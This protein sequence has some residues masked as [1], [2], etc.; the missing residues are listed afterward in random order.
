MKRKAMINNIKVEIQFYTGYQEGV[1]M[2]PIA[3][4]CCGL[5]TDVGSSPG[6]GWGQDTDPGG[7]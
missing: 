7:G 3:R 6:P 4:R 2:R 5:E 1:S